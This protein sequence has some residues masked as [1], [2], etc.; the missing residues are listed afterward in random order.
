M[1]FGKPHGAYFRNIFHI[2]KQTVREGG[3]TVRKIGVL[4]LCALLFLLSLASCAPEKGDYFAPFRGQFEATLAGEWQSMP[5]EAH[6]SASAPDERGARVMTLTFYAPKSLAGTVLARDATG[7]L[8]LSLEGLSLPLSPA[9]ASGYGALLA[10][11][12]T[13]GEVR[14]ITR[15][16]GNTRLNGTVFSLLFAADGT[17]LAAEN[18]VARVEVKEWAR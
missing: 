11:F 18:A 1:S 7:A 14:E 15:E 9:A 3:A 16:N 2:L 8:T 13:E 12:P 6:L 17:P 5:F 10:L 4:L